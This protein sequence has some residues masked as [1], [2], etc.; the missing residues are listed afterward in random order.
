MAV[1]R[2]CFCT[3][4]YI[5]SSLFLPLC[6]RPFSNVRRMPSTVVDACGLAPFSY[7]L[8]NKLSKR[9][10]IGK[11]GD[12]AICAEK[13]TYTYT[14][15]HTLILTLCLSPHVEGKVVPLSSAR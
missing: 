6:S 10:R 13:G 14:H 15:T 11:S 5:A 9:R 1:L 4:A 8:A 2:S 7:S 3:C 12:G